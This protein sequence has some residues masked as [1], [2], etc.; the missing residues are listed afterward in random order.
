M[1]KQKYKIQLFTKPNIC[2]NIKKRTNV[3]HTVGCDEKLSYKMQVKL[4]KYDE[5]C[6][7]TAKNA[8]MQ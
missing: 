7:N 5:K 4:H 1:C 6:K 2:T 8:R 3:P